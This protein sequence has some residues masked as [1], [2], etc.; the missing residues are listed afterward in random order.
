MFF[1]E[2][3][4]RTKFI[5]PPLPTSQAMAGISPRAPEVKI[6]SFFSSDI[7]CRPGSPFGF[8]CGHATLFKATKADPS[9]S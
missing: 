2:E 9:C 8:F 4:K 5:S 3:K 6:F 7:H 1:S